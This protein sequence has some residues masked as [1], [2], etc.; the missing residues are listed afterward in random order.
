MIEID[1]AVGEGGGQMLR[2][3]LSLSLMTGKPF[4]MVNIRAK[5]P[6]PGLRPQHRQCVLAAAQVSDAV[7]TGAEIGAQQLVFQPRALR[8][9]NYHFDIGTAGSTALLL[10]A[11]YLPL[12][13]ASGD[14]ELVLTG[15]THVPFAPCYHYLEGQWAPWLARLG[16]HLRLKLDRAGYY[17][18]G[19]GRIRAHIARVPEVNPVI[20]DER[21]ELRRCEVISGVTNLPFS[22]AERQAARAA[23]QLGR[24]GLEPHLDVREIAG[25]GKGTF[26]VVVVRYEHGSACYSALGAPGKPAEKVA[27]E[28]CAAFAAFH[29]SEATVD[30]HLGD[31]LLLPLAVARGASRFRVPFVTEH[32]R[33]NA[34]VL[35]S[36]LPVRIEFTESERGGTV[37]V[38]P[39]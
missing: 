16:L 31:Q 24:L 9:G 30:E 27:D 11:L 34:A 3:A 14:S 20:A 12:A 37:S 32:M 6:E 18:Q 25:R 39:G 19:G 21:G 13:L 26:V 8:W 33:T 7:V 29:R 35:S 15:G 36:F 5:R 17:P 1:G 10:H 28:A 2:T 38:R 22:I 4:T 23:R